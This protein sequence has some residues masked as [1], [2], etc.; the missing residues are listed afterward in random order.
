M[1]VEQA[2]ETTQRLANVPLFHGLQ[3]AAL[4][5]A[6]GLARSKAVRGGGFFFH[7]G[8]RAEGF[9]VLTSGRVKM[10]QLTPEGHQVVLRLVGPG[11]PFGGVGAF[12]DPT[13]PVSAEAVQPSVALVWTSTVLRRLLETEPM[14][15]VS[16]G[17]YSGSS[18]T[19]AA[20]WMQV[21]R[22]RFPYL[23]RTLRK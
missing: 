5:R 12:G 1:A 10:T 3:Q 8:D 6:V 13:Y 2:A 7:E 9:F 23:G 21:S 16:P 19:R 11:E 20:G 17:R 4:T 22:S 15:A 14:V 18:T